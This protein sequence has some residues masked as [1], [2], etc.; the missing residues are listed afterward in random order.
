MAACFQ[1]D[2]RVNSKLTPIFRFLSHS[3]L[4]NWNRREPCIWRGALP[5]LR[6]CPNVFQP[7][8]AC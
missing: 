4:Q 6:T 3:R 1:G 2:W 5:W 7:D 8:F